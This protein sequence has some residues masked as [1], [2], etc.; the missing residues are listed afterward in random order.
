M[1]AA[2]RCECGDR[3]SLLAIFGYETQL[4]TLLSSALVAGNEDGEAEGG[5]ILRVRNHARFVAAIG[6]AGVGALRGSLGGVIPAPARS[7]DAVA[8][9]ANHEIERSALRRMGSGFHVG[10]RVL[11]RGWLRHCR[12]SPFVVA[13]STERR[14]RPLP[15][16]GERA[17][18]PRGVA[19]RRILGVDR[20][21]SQNPSTACRRARRGSASRSEG[22][23]KKGTECMTV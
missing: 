12:W 11:V 13:F 16:R 8:G 22:Q 15:S 4:R 2:L 6:Q 10:C 5:R 9:G 7:G 20:R 1:Y 3:A 18:E 19:A 14:S 21:G 23:R 17:R